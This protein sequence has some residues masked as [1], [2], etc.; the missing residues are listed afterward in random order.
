ML[1]TSVDVPIFSSVESFTAEISAP[2]MGTLPD[3]TTPRMVLPAVGG[4]E[5]AIDCACSRSAGKIKTGRTKTSR[6]QA[7]NE[8][9]F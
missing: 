9:C 7:W 5:G 6:A 1:S 8:A 3:L 4:V 2:G